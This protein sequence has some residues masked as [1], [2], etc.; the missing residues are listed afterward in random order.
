MKLYS[1]DALHSYIEA[2]LNY[3]EMNLVPSKA[4]QEKMGFESLTQS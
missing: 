2:I 4:L 3:V 1:S